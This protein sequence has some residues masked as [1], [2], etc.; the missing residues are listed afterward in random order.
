[1]VNGKRQSDNGLDNTE[2][3]FKKLLHNAKESCI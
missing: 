2:N 3:N 1:M